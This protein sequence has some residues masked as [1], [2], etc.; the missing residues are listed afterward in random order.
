MSHKPNPFS[1][2]KEILLVTSRRMDHN[3]RVA[4]KR[5]GERL[6]LSSRQEMV[7]ARLGIVTMKMDRGGWICFLFQR[8]D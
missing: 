1:R 8:F 4:T 6:L 2:F 5:T 3:G 7:K